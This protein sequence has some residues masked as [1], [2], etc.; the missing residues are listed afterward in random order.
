MDY[1]IKDRCL[2]ISDTVLEIPEY[3]FKGNCDFDTVVIPSNIIFVGR[4]AFECCYGLKHVIF[5]KLS[6]CHFLPDRCFYLC[7]CLEEIQLPY[8][9]KEI[10]E[11]CFGLTR[12]LK[13]VKIPASIEFVDNMAFKASGLRSLIFEGNPPALIKQY[14]FDA[15]GQI[16]NLSIK[17]RKYKTIQ[18]CEANTAVLTSQKV[19][20]NKIIQKGISLNSFLLGGKDIWYKIIDE[21]TGNYAIHTNL[22]SAFNDLQSKNN[23]D[24]QNIVIKEQWTVDTPIDINQY[25]TMSKNCIYYTEIFMKS[26]GYS[27]D[28]KIPIKDILRVSRGQRNYDVFVDFVRKYVQGGESI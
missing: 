22:K 1:I 26:L 6:K 25:C 27:L 5:E 9:I 28:A 16:D 4:G 3:F 7:L 2:Y 17:G 13:E 21:Q 20:Q 19:F 15:V 8:K 23:N 12:N 18:N 11:E 10:G 24:L 14:S